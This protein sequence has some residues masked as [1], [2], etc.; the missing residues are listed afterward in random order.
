M[1]SEVSILKK[2]TIRAIVLALGLCLFSFVGCRNDNDADPSNP[3]TPNQENN[4][5][6]EENNEMQNNQMNQNQNMNG[7]N[8]NG[9]NM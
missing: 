5:I 4:N 7:G 3:N 1:Q 6:I 9:G 2:N 8:M